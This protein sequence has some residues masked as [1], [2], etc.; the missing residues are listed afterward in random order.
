MHGLDKTA[1]LGVVLTDDGLTVVGR[2]VPGLEVRTTESGEIQLKGSSIARVDPSRMTGD[3][4]N[5]GDLGRLAPLGLVVEGRLDDL[6][7]VAGRNIH[8]EDVEGAVATVK[9]IRAGNVVAVP[10]RRHGTDGIAVIAETR[11]FVDAGAVADLVYDAIGIRPC[12][13]RLLEPGRLPK[14]SSGKL[15]R[16]E[17]ARRFPPKEAP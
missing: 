10:D 14:T 13:V 8:P 12:G 2:P 17:A 16:R 5:T 3:W 11:G 1:R 4:L 15:R 9:G 6:I 7:I